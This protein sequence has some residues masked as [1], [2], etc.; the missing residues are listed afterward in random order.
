MWFQVGGGGFLLLFRPN[1]MTFLLRFTI[2]EF[3]LKLLMST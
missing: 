1:I 2:F 3:K